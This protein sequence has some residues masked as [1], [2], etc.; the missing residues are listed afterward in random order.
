MREYIRA[1]WYLYRRSSTRIVIG[2][3]FCVLYFLA[4]ILCGIMPPGYCVFVVFLG[5]IAFCLLFYPLYSN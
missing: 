3:I 4:Q 5:I 1:E 2:M